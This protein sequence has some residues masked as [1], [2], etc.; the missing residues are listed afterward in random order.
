MKRVLTFT[1][2]I[3]LISQTISEYS[4]FVIDKKNKFEKSIL[5]KESEICNYL[6]KIDFTSTTLYFLTNSIDKDLNSKFNIA[7]QYY[8]EQNLEMDK[9]FSYK[10]SLED[11]KTNFVTC[12]EEIEIENK[13]IEV[14]SEKNTKDVFGEIKFNSEIVVIYC[15]SKSQKKK[16]K[17]KLL[18]RH[19]ENVLAEY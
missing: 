2:L 8:V 18:S 16:K 10:N 3:L 11:Y 17:N 7:L 1:I 5:I 15:N 14:V 9:Y 12:L 6:K 19:N 13:K 4:Y